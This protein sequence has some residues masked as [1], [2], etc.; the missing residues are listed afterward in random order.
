MNSPRPDERAR[1]AIRAAETGDR[2]VIGILVDR[3]EDPDEG[4]RFYAI[5]ALERLT[6]TRMGYDYRVGWSQRRR[7][8]QEWRR[9]LAEQ[10]KVGTGRAG[11]EG[12]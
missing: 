10:V 9:Y 1:A 7:A 8:V 12:G 4:V 6:G 11:G 3:L 2:D 5:L